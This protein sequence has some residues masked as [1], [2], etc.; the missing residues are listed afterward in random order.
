MPKSDEASVEVGGKTITRWS[1]YEIESDL[2]KPA[3]TFRLTIPMRGSNADR[4]AL[5][6]LVVPGT[7]VKVHVGRGGNKS[8]QMTGLIGRRETGGDRQG[9]TQLTI[10]GEDMGQHLTRSDV[11][12]RTGVSATEIRYTTVVPLAEGVSTSRTVGATFTDL[13]RKLVSP[14]DIPVVTDGTAARDMLSGR[15]RSGAK[16]RLAA[17]M[18]ANLGIPSNVFQRSMVGRAEVAGV[19]VDTLAGV[20]ASDAGRSRFA[21]SLTSSDI[22]RLTIN[23]AKPSVGESIWDFI[24]RHAKRFGLMAWMSPDGKLILSSPNYGS[25]PLFRLVRRLREKSDDLNTIISGT[26]RDD[27]DNRFSHVK[28]YGRGPRNNPQRSRYTATAVDT[29]MSVYRPKHLH[30]NSVRSDEDAQK[31]AQRE[32]TLAAAQ[33][34]DYDCT[35]PDHGQGTYLY[36]TDQMCRVLDEVARVD[37]IYHIVARTFLKMRGQG[38]RSQS[39]IT[40]LR[41]KPKGSIALWPPVLAPEG[42]SNVSGAL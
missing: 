22:E 31:R 2:L 32:V 33:S 36:S 4:E 30:D 35:V 6:A 24:D 34:F 17:D 11:D 21:N 7:P 1:K 3:D 9:G 42:N 13:V 29:E 38:T 14:W 19:P 41:L 25:A 39:T 27:I 8:L 16:G 20:T 18:A 15:S 28:V 5:H 10:A 37:G 40:R 26:A 12:P 23:E